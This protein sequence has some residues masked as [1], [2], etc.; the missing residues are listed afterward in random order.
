MSAF[1]PSS[2]KGNNKCGHY[3]TVYSGGLPAQ[4]DRLGPNIGGHP[5]LF[6]IHQMNYVNSRYRSAMM[7]GS[8]HCLSIAIIY[9]ATKATYIRLLFGKMGVFRP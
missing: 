2:N 5:V 9:V 6:C 3:G 7:I 8:N 4:A 1:G